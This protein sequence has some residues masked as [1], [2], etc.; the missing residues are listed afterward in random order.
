MLYF[1]PTP[2]GNL[3]DIT[4]RA[5]EALKSADILVCEN[6]RHSQVLLKHY[7]ISKP[8]WQINQHSLESSI[9]KVIANL[10]SGRTIAYLSDAGTPGISDPGHELIQAALQAN[11]KFTVLPGASAVLPA[12]VASGLISKD[13]YFGGFL[14]LKKGRQKL[15]T[16]LLLLPFPVVVYESPYRMSKLLRELVDLGAGER[17]VCIARELSKLYEE[18]IYGTASDLFAKHGEREWKGEYV[19]VIAGSYPTHKQED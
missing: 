17:K 16:S 14:P 13:F 4:L 7:E 8:V 11:I 1:V 5:L 3:S 6:P 2:I 15:L 10:Q 12:A 18:Y 19:V 9:Q